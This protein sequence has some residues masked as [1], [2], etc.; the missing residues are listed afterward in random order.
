[1]AKLPHTGS[2]TCSIKLWV[3]IILL[4]PLDT[5]FFLVL[6]FYLCVHRV[7]VL[8]NVR[9]LALQHVLWGGHC[10]RDLCTSF[11][12][13][14][15]CSGLLVPLLGQWWGQPSPS[16]LASSIHGGKTEVVL[17]C[18]V[19]HQGIYVLSRGQHS[20]F[21]SSEGGGILSFMIKRG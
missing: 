2:G 13:G 5:L 14:A 11:S 3:V 12:R 10:H 1:M 4:C 17:T 7:L 21:L 19:S 6:R 8:Q 18:W 20:F 16:L 15:S 9:A